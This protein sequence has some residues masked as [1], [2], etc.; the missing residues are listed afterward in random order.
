MSFSKRLRAPRDDRGVVAEPPLAEGGKV[1]AENRQLFAETDLVFLGRPLS[2]LRRRARH[3]IIEKSLAY[4]QA[5]G[6]PVLKT[7][8]D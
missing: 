8:A 1:L 7:N 4:L 2:E 5:A 6:E 3:D